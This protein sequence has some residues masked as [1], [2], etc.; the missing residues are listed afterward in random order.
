[1]N[2]IQSENRALLHRLQKRQPTYN[3]TH[4]EHER[5]YQ[6]KLIQKISMYPLSITSMTKRKKSVK[7]KGLLD[8]EKRFAS[9]GTNRMM[10]E[11]YRMRDPANAE[12]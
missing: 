9:T 2:R 8:M 1:M 4:W 6:V 3:V 12:S 11:M 10:F 5:K 7:K